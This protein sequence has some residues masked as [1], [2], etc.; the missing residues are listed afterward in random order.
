MK[1]GFSLCPFN[2]RELVQKLVYGIAT[3]QVLKQNVSWDACA[4]K[5]DSARN[6]LRIA[7][8]DIFHFHRAFSELQRMIH[9]T[10][11]GPD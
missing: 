3:S 8:Y 5:H 6:D 10:P 1:K 2:G 9:I 11:S 4:L 7:A